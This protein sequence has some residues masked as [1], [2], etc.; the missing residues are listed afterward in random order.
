MANQRSHER[1]LQLM[2]LRLRLHHDAA[3]T[4]SRRL[5]AAGQLASAVGHLALPSSSGRVK[6]QENTGRRGADADELAPPCIAS[7]SEP[8]HARNRGIYGTCPERHRMSHYPA[9][10]AEPRAVTTSHS[11][12]L[13]ESVGVQV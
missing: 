13:G 4:P 3:I 1:L 5:D 9:V 11:M 8:C 7:L 10:A 2:R 12:D 6:M